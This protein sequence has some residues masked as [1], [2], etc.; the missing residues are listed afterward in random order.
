MLDDFE[1]N[2]MLYL[3]KICSKLLQIT[4]IFLLVTRFVP[5][6]EFFVDSDSVP[7]QCP[8]SDEEKS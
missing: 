4:T 3:N 6:E 8:P 1:V 5:A 2:S 7:G